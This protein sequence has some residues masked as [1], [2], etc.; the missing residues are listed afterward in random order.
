MP[1]RRNGHLIGREHPAAVLR[2]EFDRAR[3]SHGGLVLVTGEAG[4][5]KTALVTE[6]ADEARRHGV[7]V[8]SGACWDSA[9]APGFWP[10]VQVV[11][12]LRRSVPPGEWAAAQRAAGAELAVLLGEAPG[13]APV[14]P[15]RL[16]D[17]VTTA[18]VSVSQLRPVAVVLDDLHAADPAS[19]KLCEFAARHTW[20]ERLVL[21][22]T[23]RDD[24]VEAAEHPLRPLLT[25]LPAKARTVSLTGLSPD[26]VGH[27][28]TRTAGR[29]PGARLAAAVH[30]RT[31]G[32]PFFVEQA[33]RLWAG[34]R[35]VTA[36]APG[37]RETVRRRLSLLPDAVV[38]L[39][40]DA[41]VLGPEFDRQV[42]AASAGLALPRV[43]QLLD[44]AVAARLVVAAGNGRFGFVHDLV[45]ETL[46]ASLDDA[47]ERHAA[48][49]RALD[50]S[51]ELAGR[52][53]PAD[54]ARH[55]LLAGNRLEPGRAVDLL[56]VAARD[57]AR[58]MA[59]DEAI[60]HYR[61]ALDGTG[62]PHRRVVIAL[63]LGA[64][65]HHAGDRDEAWEVL[66]SAATSA[67]ELG[68][69]AL[70]TRAA[71][72]LHRIGDAGEQAELKLGLLTE[73]HRRLFAAEGER[74]PE[75]L[76]RE[77]TGHLTVLARRGGDDEVLGFSLWTL[78]DAIWGPGTAAERQTLA[79]ELAVIGRRSAD[80]EMEQ[81][82]A[83]L[84]WAAL[85]EQGDPR[86]F[87]QLDEFVAMAEREGGPPARIS[88]YVDRS[89]TA[90]LTG[91]FEQAEVCH[92]EAMRLVPA[93]ERHRYAF[94]T[95]HLWWARTLLRGRFDELERLSQDFDHPFPRLIEAVTAVQRGDLGVAVRYLREAPETLPR[96][97]V[98]LWLRFQAQ[99]AAA[100]RDPALCE[101][102]RAAL[103]PLAGQWL[104]SIFGCDIS[105]PVSLWLAKLDAA[106]ARWDDAVEGFTAALREAET[107]RAR[108]WAVEARTGL[109]AALLGR[110]APGDR[111]E[112]QRLAKEAAREAA[113]LG[114]PKSGVDL[115]AGNE[116]R[117][118]GAVWSLG[119]AGRTVHLP[120]AK[121]L[122]DLHFLLGRPGVEVPAVQLLDPAGGELV[123]AARRFGGDEVLDEEARARYRD[124]LTVL[125]EQI[126]RALERG[127]DDKAA[128]FDAERQALLDELRVA[129]GLA[130]R[131]RR[132]G[133]E[134]ER[135]RKAVTARIRDVLRKLD[136][137]HPE[138]AAHLRATVSTG[139]S[140]CYRPGRETAWRL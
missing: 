138:L 49:V 14:E 76:V 5:G 126:D 59:A 63:K 104:V 9:S 89:I 18:L 74:P 31:G 34:G 13:S 123:V 102:A 79:E 106:Q 67:R 72:T 37:V 136:G 23:Y 58:R 44:Q 54:L 128:A 4:I 64:Q 109:A 25:S 68:E 62:E 88:A 15:F 80:P 82:A 119:M 19:L 125:D 40:G 93:D 139:T 122:R 134:T 117:F 45:R 53:F 65:L 27:L 91:E 47:G 10:W 20:F 137:H 83:S 86:C 26:E 92:D 77:L 113:A 103:A 114:L 105:G 121:G 32:N 57:A 100:V 127:D 48:V 108:P 110:G 46:Y 35:S 132:L 6:A 42:L 120:D 7:L 70:L 3:E 111:A 11:R 75:Q 29:E 55:G 98:P 115:F 140:C 39:L 95:E 116:F 2:A 50:R 96:M 43:E 112:A 17:A 85:L 130:G 36:I 71:L 24:E 118:T 28:M 101:R 21:V 97:I 8:L 99:L 135:A 124:R 90:T 30:R 51:P 87:A 16:F 1:H 81:H 107:L 41:A 38:R 129:A 60:A 94:V 73:A 22:G 56:L 84:R 66:R 33:A 131:P 52:V 12:A 133:D 78:H 61:R 69:P